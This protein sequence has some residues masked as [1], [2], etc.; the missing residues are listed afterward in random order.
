MWQNT[1]VASRSNSSPI[2]ILNQLFGGYSFLLLASNTSFFFAGTV[3]PWISP[4]LISVTFSLLSK[5]KS[6]GDI[7]WIPPRVSQKNLDNS[8]TTQE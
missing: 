6:S 2:V 8:C 1:F 7:P 3:S 4:L 5:V